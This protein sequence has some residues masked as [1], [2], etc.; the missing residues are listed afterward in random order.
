MRHYTDTKGQQH[1]VEITLR[2]RAAIKAR[3]D[4][5]L[6]A[7]A[8]KPDVL[9][10]LLS[11]VVEDDAFLFELLSII[12]GV[13]LE[14][15]QNAADG[16]T[17]EAASQAFLEALIDFFPAS[18]PLRRPL[19]E[20]NTKALAHHSNVAGTIEAGMLQTVSTMDFPTALSGSLTVTNGSAES[21]PAAA[22]SAANMSL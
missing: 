14:S 10:G 20:L 4:L 12:E 5:D 19:R 17:L 3:H 18:S 1:A 8:S 11:R 7:C 16:S 6:L 2:T 21:L 9:E 22:T 15:L 13:P